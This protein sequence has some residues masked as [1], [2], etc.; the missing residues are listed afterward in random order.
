[1]GREQF[2]VLDSMDSWSWIALNVAGRVYIY[3]CDRRRPL[4]RDLQ[5]GNIDISLYNQ[6]Q[7]SWDVTPYTDLGGYAYPAD[8]EIAGTSST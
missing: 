4:G 5:G 8:I 6:S 7:D 3:A 2:H 1:M